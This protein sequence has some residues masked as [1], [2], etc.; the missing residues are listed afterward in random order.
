M[1]GLE[2]A[3]LAAT[4]GCVP[5][6]VAVGSIAVRALVAGTVVVVIVT[7]GRDGAAVAAGFA[8]AVAVGGIAV[9]QER[10][11]PLH[12]GG[13][14]ELVEGARVTVGFAGA[15]PHVGGGPDG[16]ELFTRHPREQLTHAVAVVAADQ[17]HVLL[18]LL[19]PR[20]DTLGVDV[21]DGTADR[22]GV[23]RRSPP[24]RLGQHHV[25]HPPGQ[26]EGQRRGQL[27]KFHRLVP[28][29]VTS[30][31]RAQRRRQPGVQRDAHVDQVGRGA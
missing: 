24:S 29:Q 9:V 18:R 10:L 20:R 11:G 1:V 25:F 30:T 12:E 17:L 22:V 6:G 14:A 3:L 2:V 4:G 21:G 31:D 15:G 26:V 27:G 28:G 23:P 8:P 7:L 16:V 5:V 19:A 13:D